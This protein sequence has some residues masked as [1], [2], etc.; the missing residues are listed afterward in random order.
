[1]TIAAGSTGNR[2]YTATWTVNQYAMTFVLDNG[3]ENVVKTQDFGSALTAPADLA[4]TGYTFTGWSPAIPETVPAENK[5][6]TAQWQRNN[7]KVTWVVDGQNTENTVAYEDVIT[8]PTDP[9]KEGHTFKGWDAEIPAKMPANDLTF[10]AQF[11][12]NVYAVIYL[13][14]NIEWSR[15]SVA[16]GTT[17]VKKNYEQE[18][19]EFEGWTSDAEYTTMPAHD[20]VYNAQLTPTSIMRILGEAKTVNVYRM[21]GTLVGRNL[22]VKELKKRLTKG[23]YIING[24][25]FIVK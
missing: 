13:V 4:K 10:T 8:V 1:V 2:T 6:F 5:T 22:S 11:E 23:V 20:V 24:K 3:Q 14:N 12:V 25:K 18:G 16:Y 17:I 19:Y 21:D 7:Y 15:D 9:T